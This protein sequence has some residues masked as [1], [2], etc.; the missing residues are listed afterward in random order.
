MQT[1]SSLCDR[2]GMSPEWAVERLRY[3][4]I[5]VEGP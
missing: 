2:L 3:V 5:E 4:F 1:V